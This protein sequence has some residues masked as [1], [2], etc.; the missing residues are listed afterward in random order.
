MVA[1]ELSRTDRTPLP[2]FTVLFVNG[3]PERRARPTEIPQSNQR[4]AAA[5]T[6]QIVGLGGRT[7]KGPP[8]GYWRVVSLGRLH[9]PS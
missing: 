9:Q 2:A 6:K 7:G 1:K 8:S 5:E 4:F 3:A